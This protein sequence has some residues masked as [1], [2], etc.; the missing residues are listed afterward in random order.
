[1]LDALSTLDTYIYEHLTKKLE[2]YPCLIVFVSV[3]IFNHTL[4]TFLYLSLF[5]SLKILLFL[6][7]QNQISN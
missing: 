2:M 5:F 3:H 1:M 4:R 7:T 6:S